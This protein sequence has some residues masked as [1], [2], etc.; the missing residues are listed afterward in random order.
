L[1]ITV[2]LLLYSLLYYRIFLSLGSINSAC[3]TMVAVVGWRGD[4]LS[5]DSYRDHAGS[6]SNIVELE[7]QKCGWTKPYDDRNVGVL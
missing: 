6:A 7:E 1:P 4:G 5:S 3:S 2:V